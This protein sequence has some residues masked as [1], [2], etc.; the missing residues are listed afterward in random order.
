MDIYKLGVFEAHFFLIHTMDSQ[1]SR[2]PR[3]S[4][5]ASEFPTNEAP[6][7][8]TVVRG[9]GFSIKEDRL[10]VSSWLNTSLN[11]VHEKEQK[12]QAFGE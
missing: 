8:K 4:G 7:E 5:E 6:K 12:L 9:V 1:F 3:F 11:A 10:F 2:F